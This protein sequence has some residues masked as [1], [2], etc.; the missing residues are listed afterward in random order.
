MVFSINPTADKTQAMF[1]SL[2]IAQNGTGQ[3]TPITGGAGSPPANAPAVS[4]SSSAGVA[5]PTGG[6]GGGGAVAPG[7]GTVGADGSC[8]CVAA[9]N[10]G[11]FPAQNQGV[12]SFGGMGGEKMLNTLGPR[13]YSY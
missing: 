1:Q 6:V 10:V 4:V 2:A 5:Q 8:S 13:A 12:G 7:Q 9:C 11:S 3:A